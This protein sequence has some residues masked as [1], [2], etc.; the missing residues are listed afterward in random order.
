MLPIYI[1]KTLLFIDGDFRKICSDAFAA[2]DFEVGEG[3]LDTVD[4][5]TSAA[6]EGVLAS[7]IRAQLVSLIERRGVPLC[8][9]LAFPSR[10]GIAKDKDPDG[11]LVARSLFLAFISIGMDQKY[12]S[13]RFHLLVIVNGED[14]ARIIEN[15]PSKLLSSLKI[16]NEK[17]N[18]RIENLVNDKA[19]FAQSFLVK[20]VDSDTFA[21]HPV[22][23]VKGFISQINARFK[24]ETR[25][26]SSS[27]PKISTKNDA[28]AH[29]IFILENGVKYLNGNIVDSISEA[30]GLE[31]NRF[32]LLGS[33]TTKNLKDVMNLIK[34]GVTGGFRD[35][36]FAADDEIVICLGTNCMIDATAATGFAQLLVSELARYK[37]KKVLASS[38]N[39]GILRRSHGYS[40]IREFIRVE[41]Y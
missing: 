1:K 25:I 14:R 3:I 39:D 22:L 21:A 8:F 40:M 4:A 2:N 11:T 30:E 32:H 16:S 31:P 36:K 34:Q 37:K 10:M 6:D 28:P 33:L 24:L 20:A 38:V 26:T 17:I 7:F 12:T 23:M 5:V 35:V 27:P 9:V 15:T 19:A 41:H 29:L 18:A 13:A